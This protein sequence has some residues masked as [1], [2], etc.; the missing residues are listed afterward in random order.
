MSD[1]KLDSL[2]P[3]QQRQA[4]LSRWD[5]EGG[6]GPCGSQEGQISEE[7]QSEVPD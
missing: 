2:N 7:L 1:L 6:A 3:S 4:A 5:N